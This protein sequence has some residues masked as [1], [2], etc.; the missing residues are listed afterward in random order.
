MIDFID[1]QTGST[2]II[3]S[4]DPGNNTAVP[5]VPSVPGLKF[6]RGGRASVRPPSRQ[7]AFGSVFRDTES[8]PTIVN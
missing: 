2:I 1:V 8:D 6:G 3:S 7:L 5:S 4:S